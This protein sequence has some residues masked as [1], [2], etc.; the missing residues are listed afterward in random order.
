MSADTDRWDAR[1]LRRAAHVFDLAFTA[2]EAQLATQFLKDAAHAVAARRRVFQPPLDLYP[3]TVYRPFPT[4]SG[5]QA[6]PGDLRKLTEWPNARGESARRAPDS[7]PDTSADL[8]LLFLSLVDQ[9]RLLRTGAVTPD[10]LLAAAR[11][12]LESVNSTINA[13]VTMIDAEASHVGST[14]DEG[15]LAGIPYGAKDLFDTAGVETTFGAEP[16]RGRIPE[17]DATVVTRCRDAGAVLVAKLSLGELAMGDEW[18]GG[19]TNNPW[20]PEHGAGGSSAGSAA[21]VAAGALSFA[22]GTETSGS[23]ITPS[24]RCGV[25]GLRP[26]FGRVAR[27]GAMPLSWSFDKIG[28][29][30]RH[31]RDAGVVL[32]AIAG[33]DE[34]D[35]DSV[36]NVF[37]SAADERIL[38]DSAPHFTVGYMPRW[39]DT[40]GASRETAE[41]P[42]AVKQSVLTNLERDQRFTLRS[43]DVPA[44][45]YKNLAYLLLTDAA[46]VF[47]DLTLSGRVDLLAQQDAASWP[48]TFR[49]GHL[50]SAVEHVQLQR[51]RRH[52]ISVVE[53][54]LSEVDML[55]A[56]A[57]A[58]QGDILVL[59][60]ATGHPSL[61]FPIGFTGD[62]M[63]DSLTLWGRPYDEAR[64]IRAAEVIMESFNLQG[65]RPLT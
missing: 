33:P 32:S 12:R 2:E 49:A 11:R 51:F 9:L 54:L 64:M 5:A 20:N 45:P 1:D 25:V 46:A 65:A 29:I 57:Y 56:P 19:R 8:D 18:F 22:L 44:L 41:G 30:T 40:Q 6:E 52:C 53:T 38:G 43:V 10:R 63:P 55:I 16:F 47:E 7:S 17:R 50:L 42:S 62:G 28:P 3:A 48:N 60:T 59:T 14:G 37:P 34:G 27:T 31:P 13:V 15:A 24:M 61:T 21:A 4:P 58:D 35:P 39:F 23:I 36:A 26:T